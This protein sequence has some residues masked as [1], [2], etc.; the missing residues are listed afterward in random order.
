MFLPSP[1]LLPLL[2]PPLPPLSD[3]T[4][5]VKYN[6]D[7]AS[8]VG[9]EMK[10]SV[11]GRGGR[12][13]LKDFPFPWSPFGLLPLPPSWRTRCGNG[14]TGEWLVELKWITNEWKERKKNQPGVK[15][16]LQGEEG[17]G[18]RKKLCL[19]SL[20]VIPYWICG[21][22][23]KT[24]HNIKKKQIRFSRTSIE[25]GIK[26]KKKSLLGLIFNGNLTS[27]TA[28]VWRKRPWPQRRRKESRLSSRKQSFSFPSHARCLFENSNS[29]SLMIPPLVIC[30]IGCCT[31]RG[32]C[33]LRRSTMGF[34]NC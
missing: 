31:G 15:Q 3:F 14:I 10:G 29:P 19:G 27:W 28:I 18:K 20:F 8:E 24:R 34:A 5:L 9:W 4:A 22:K 1:P 13:K 21:K 30:T 6:Y 7:E 11:S 26:K 25:R 16:E 23:K 2:L 12:R 33:E 17:G 32:R